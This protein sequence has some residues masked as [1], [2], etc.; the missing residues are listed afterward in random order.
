M[1]RA[2][3]CACDCPST[4]QLELR[5]YV[6]VDFPCPSNTMLAP[7]FSSIAGNR[8]C[9]RWL[10]E[11]REQ[12]E[13]ITSID[14]N[15][16]AGVTH[17]YPS[18]FYSYAPATDTGTVPAGQR[19]IDGY[20]AGMPPPTVCSTYPG[21]PPLPNQSPGISPEDISP[22]SSNWWRRVRIQYTF[23]YTPVGSANSAFPVNWPN[24]W[25]NIR[26]RILLPV[27]YHSAGFK[28]PATNAP[29]EGNNP[30]PIWAP[31]AITINAGMERDTLLC[32]PKGRWQLNNCPGFLGHGWYEDRV[33]S[34]NNATPSFGDQPGINYERTYKDV[35]LAPFQLWVT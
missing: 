31:A 22:F 18:E 13:T 20:T 8:N 23:T 29:Y 12:I 1:H 15:P 4:A 2:C 32:F 26:I 21:V 24:G 17:C 30:N 9:V 27:A 16:N 3:C 28:F 7:P 33:V 34:F 5:N 10:G 6:P 35:S 25:I 14:Q 19:M 11:I